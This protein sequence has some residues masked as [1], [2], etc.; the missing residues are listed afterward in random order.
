[1]VESTGLLNLRTCKCTGGSNPPLSASINRPSELSSSGGLFLLVAWVVSPHRGFDCEPWRAEAAHMHSSCGP[2][3]NVNPTPPDDTHPTRRL[4]AG[5][6]RS[7]VL[8]AFVGWRLRQD[9]SWQCDTLQQRRP[10]RQSCLS[11][12]RYPRPAHRQRVPAVSRHALTR[13]EGD[14]TPRWECRSPSTPS[15]S[16]MQHGHRRAGRPRRRGRC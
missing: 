6:A 2:A 7:G 12:R 15:R 1:V 11:A 16:P 8:A 14:T 3:R 4:R 10:R 9:R 5:E 13:R